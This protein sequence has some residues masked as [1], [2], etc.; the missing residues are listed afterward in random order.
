MIMKTYGQLHWLK[1]DWNPGLGDPV[2]SD[3][4]SVTQ[5]LKTTKPLDTYLTLHNTNF[6]TELYVVGT[7]QN[8]SFETTLM[9]MTAPFRE[10]FQ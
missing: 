1:Q 9:S 4:R 7:L 6:G 10:T 2:W 8:R 5:T 3:N